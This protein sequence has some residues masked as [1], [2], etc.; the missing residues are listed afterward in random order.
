MDMENKSIREIIRGIPH[1]ESFFQ[2]I[3]RLEEEKAK[4]VEDKKKRDAFIN[5][6]TLRLYTSFKLTEQEVKDLYSQYLKDGNAS[7]DSSLFYEYVAVKMT[8]KSAVGVSDEDDKGGKKGSNK[9]T[10]LYVG[11]GLVVA[12]L[13]AV[14]YFKNKK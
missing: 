8:P 5:E 6:S 7:L 14:L 13:G 12:T 11:I 2:R 10:Y 4:K 3:K 9:S 1:T